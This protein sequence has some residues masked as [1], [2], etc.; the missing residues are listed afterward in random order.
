MKKYFTL[1]SHSTLPKNKLQQEVWGMLENESNKVIDDLELSVVEIRNT[2]I[3]LNENYPRC[4]DLSVHEDRYSEG[5]INLHIQL[6]HGDQGPGVCF[7][8]HLI[9]E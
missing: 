2:I 6:Q 9:K 5:L 7:S 8:Y 4:Q 3:Q 1:L